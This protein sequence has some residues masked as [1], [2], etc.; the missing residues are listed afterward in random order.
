MQEITHKVA[1]KWHSTVFEVFDLMRSCWHSQ[2]WLMAAAHTLYI[3]RRHT[4]VQTSAE[5]KIYFS[6]FF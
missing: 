6:V 3:L 1:V 5:D 4:S 2:Y